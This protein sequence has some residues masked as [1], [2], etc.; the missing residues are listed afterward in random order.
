[1]AEWILEGRRA[2]ELEPFALDRF[3]GAATFAEAVIL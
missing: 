2:P 1:M 3:G